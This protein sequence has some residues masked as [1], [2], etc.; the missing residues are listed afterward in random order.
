MTASG[1]WGERWNT[2]PHQDVSKRIWKRPATRTKTSAGVRVK[3]R[4]ASNNRKAR[5]LAVGTPFGKAELHRLRDEVAV[6]RDER[7]EAAAS[8]RRAIEVADAQ[9][10]I[11]WRQRA[12]QSLTA[13]NEK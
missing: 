11:T 10:A 12:E 4:Q 13:L 9:N 8:F 1:E 7:A 6:A 2:G 5:F 3:L